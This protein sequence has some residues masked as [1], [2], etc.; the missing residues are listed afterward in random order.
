MTIEDDVNALAKV[1]LFY[2]FTNEQLRL[3]AFGT[4]HLSIS[5]G[6]ELFREGDPAECGFVVLSG[7]INLVEDDKMN[8]RIVQNVGQGTLIGELALITATNRSCG[9]VAAENSEVIRINR[10]LMRRVFD[11]YPELTAHLHADL[12]T[13]FGDFLKSITKLDRKFGG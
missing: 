12:S 5:K 4:E 8:R 2:S 11:E 7:S 6:R 1:P 10:S 13:R 3:I 9:A